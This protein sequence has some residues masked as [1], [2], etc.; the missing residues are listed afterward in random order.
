MAS[1]PQAVKL[2]KNPAAVALGKLSAASK[3]PEERKAL[4]GKGGKIGGAAR[5]KALTKKQ[6]SDIARAA[7]K[8]RW[9][10]QRKKGE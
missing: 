2:S 6:R 3:T 10:Q 8:A 1:K 9:A 7:A 4:A 5:A